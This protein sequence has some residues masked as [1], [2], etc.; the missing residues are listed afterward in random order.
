VRCI[1]QDARGQ[2]WFCSDSDI[3]RFDGRD[4]QRFEK[5]VWISLGHADTIY[6]PK[7]PSRNRDAWRF[8]RAPSNGSGLIRSHPPG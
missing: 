3:F 2:V 8:M 5:T 7:A 6:D 4:L 1:T